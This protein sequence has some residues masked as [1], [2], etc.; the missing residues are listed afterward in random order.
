MSYAPP[1]RIRIC[2][3]HALPAG[4]RWVVEINNS[5]EALVLNVDGVVY[6][7]S[8]MCLHAGAALQHGY[9]EGRVLYGPLHRW[10]FVL[11]T[12]AWAEDATLR[13]PTYAIAQQDGDC[14]LCLP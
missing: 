14:F 2:A 11:T 3:V 13:A 1:K 7:M 12:G 10:G 4:T 8:T 5:E 6:A 9:V